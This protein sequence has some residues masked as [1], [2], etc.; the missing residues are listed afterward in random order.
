MGC[1]LRIIVLLLTG[2]MLAG[3]GAA[4][5]TDYNYHAPT[6]PRG[7]MCASQCSQ[8][9]TLCKRSAGPEQKLRCEEEYRS[10]YQLCGGEVIPHRHCVA[11]CNES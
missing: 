6:Q 11:F 8:S 3:C 10:C 9:K 1:K 4:Y 2:F 7:K 5:K